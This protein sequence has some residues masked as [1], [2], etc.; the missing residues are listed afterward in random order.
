M[1]ARLPKTSNPVSN[2]LSNAKNLDAQKKEFFDG[3][4]I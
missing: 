3:I 2:V 4:Q 1:I